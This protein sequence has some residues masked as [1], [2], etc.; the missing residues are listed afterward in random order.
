MTKIEI[1]KHWFSLF[2]GLILFLGAIWFVSEEF[3]QL[4]IQNSIYSAGLGLAFSFFL[5][6]IQGLEL[7]LLLKKRN[8]LLEK[9]D[10]VTLPFSMNLWGHFIP[11]QGGFLYFLTFIKSKYGVSVFSLTGAYFWLFFLGL[12]V[13]GTMG[14]MLLVRFQA[15]WLLILWLMGMACSVFVLH[16][17]AS[18]NHFKDIEAG[19]GWKGKIIQRIQ[20]ALEGFSQFK[21]ADYLRFAGISALLTALTSL[22]GWQISKEFGFGID[23]A[24]VF[25]A[26]VLMRIGLL[27]KITPGN[28]G[29]LQ[30]GSGAVFTALGYSASVGIF[31]SVWQQASMLLISIPIGLAGTWLNRHQ[32]SWKSLFSTTRP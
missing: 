22:W 10:T 29:V 7:L 32:F 4:N 14:L 30:L 25:Y 23:L 3:N 12:S 19:P 17:L 6:L 9:K 24:G 2:L 21:A 1:K 26:T 16:G 8:V 5:F 27:L 13:D 11:V 15:S 18:M 20:M 31:I 28:L